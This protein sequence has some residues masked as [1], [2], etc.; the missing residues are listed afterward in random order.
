MVKQ[1]T[2]NTVHYVW[3]PGDMKEWRRAALALV[4]GLLVFAGVWIFSR[5]LLPAVVF[6]TSATAG[7]TGVNFGRRDAQA[8]SGFPDLS[9]RAARRAAMVHTG[10]AAWRALVQGCFAAGAAVLIVNLPATGVVA[11][12]LLPVV[13]AV[14][15]TLA[16]QAGMLHER[17]G[18]SASTPGPAK[19][20]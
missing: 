20:A 3:Y 8:Y 12:W 16:R 2:E 1:V 5:D 15:G 4:V 11:N 17:L 7:V 10:R 13:P 14:V 18:V 6:G 9:D 19:T